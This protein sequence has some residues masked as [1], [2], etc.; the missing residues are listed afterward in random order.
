MDK[1]APVSRSWGEVDEREYEPAE[2]EEAAEGV[3]AA[4]GADVASYYTA[5]EEA[6]LSPM[7]SVKTD[8]KHEQSFG[9]RILK[10]HESKGRQLPPC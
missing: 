9:K 8:V 6:S 4:A 7:A 10:G 1:P 2:G 3:T 5:P